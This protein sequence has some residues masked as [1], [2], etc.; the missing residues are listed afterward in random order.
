[1]RRRAL[2]MGAFVWMLCLSLA[3][4]TAAWADC[5]PRADVILKLRTQWQE[6]L[7]GQGE[8]AGTRLFELHV[9]RWGTWTLTETS[10]DGCTSVVGH[11]ND[12]HGQ[13]PRSGDPA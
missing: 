9:S 13:A 1:M 11:G 3:F 4:A 6:E 5:Q 12:W 2:Q 8:A 7:I 10:L